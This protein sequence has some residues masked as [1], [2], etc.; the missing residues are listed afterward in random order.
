MRIYNRLVINIST[1]E[2]IEE[3][4]Y[5]Y[6][7]PIMLCKKGGSSGGSNIDYAY[8]ARMAAIAEQQQ[9]QA[10]EYMDYW[11]SSVKPYEMAKIDANMTLMPF[12]VAATKETLK[13]IAELAPI[14][15]RMRK[16]FLE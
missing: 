9:A 7:G 13:G 8:N 4:S 3:N 10:T 1:G 2:V 6:S 16:S 14:E 12:E 15:T 5:E 11:R